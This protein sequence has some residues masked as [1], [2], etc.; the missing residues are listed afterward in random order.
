M[1]N[2]VFVSSPK[3]SQKSIFSFYLRGQQI[4]IS[5]HHIQSA[6]LVFY[7]KFL[8]TKKVKTMIWVALHASLLLSF[9]NQSPEPAPHEGV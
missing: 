7:S 3:T 6:I 4:N 5:Q 8:D 2:Y 9:K 1:G